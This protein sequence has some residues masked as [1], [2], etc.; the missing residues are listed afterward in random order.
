[1]MNYIKVIS[2]VPRIADERVA[3]FHAEPAGGWTQELFFFDDSN[4]TSI[5]SAEQLA[6]AMRGRLSV[7]GVRLQTSVYRSCSLLPGLPVVGVARAA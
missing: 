4:P 1:M 3:G 5:S 6:R 7:R 2:K